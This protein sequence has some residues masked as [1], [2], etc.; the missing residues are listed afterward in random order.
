MLNLKDV[1]PTPKP[2]HTSV[3]ERKHERINTRF[4]QTDVRTL[5]AE[6]ENHCFYYFFMPSNANGF[7]ECNL[8]KHAMVLITR[9]LNE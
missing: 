3:R 7:D 2:K 4:T 1:L 8:N 5:N 6:L 9:K